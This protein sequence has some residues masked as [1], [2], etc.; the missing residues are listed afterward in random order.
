M[1]K[2]LTI[3]IDPRPKERPQGRVAYTREK[4]PYVQMYTPPETK[5]YEQ[6][7]RDAWVREHGDKPMEGPLIVRVY[8]HFRIPKSDTKARKAAKL[9]G[10]MRE[11]IRED[12]DNCVKSVLDALN[13]TAYADDRQVIKLLSGKR[14]AEV[15]QVKIIISQAEEKEGEQ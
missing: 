11:E 14:Y 2:K 5:K 4:K 1:E 10:G 13:K 3:M 15:P 6:A 7:I 8:F 9:N 12:V